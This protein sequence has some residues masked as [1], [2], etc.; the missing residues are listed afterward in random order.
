[1]QNATSLCHI[2]G[3]TSI[4]VK[5]PIFSAIIPDMKIADIFGDRETL[6]L[7]GKEVEYLLKSDPKLEKTENSELKNEIRELYRKLNQN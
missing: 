4:L 1:M 7:A 2:A 3:V 5:E 6:R